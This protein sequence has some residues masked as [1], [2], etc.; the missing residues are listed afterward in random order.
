MKRNTGHIAERE[1]DVV[2]VG[3]GIFGCC[4][5][6]DAAQRGLS[7][8]LLERRDFSGATSANSFKIVHGGIRYLQ[9]GDLPRIRESSR[10]RSVLLKIAPHLVR[11]LPIVIPTYGHGKHG[12]ALLRLGC[13]VYDLLTLD[14]NR[15][16]TDA[17]RRIPPSRGLSREEVLEQ[18]PGLDPSGLTGGVLFHDGQMLDPP[19]LALCYLKSACEAGAQAA[20]YTEVTG[21]IR[22]GARVVGVEARDTLNGDE[23]DVRGKVVVNAAG[24]WVPKLLD[25][26]L[27]PERSPDLTFSR[28]ACFVVKRRLTG[29]CALAVSGRTRDP[30]A[31]LSRGKRHLF[32]APWRDYT[33]VGV[34]HKVHRSTPDDLLVTE[35][36]LDEFIAEVNETYPAAGISRDE[37]SVQN[38][39]LVLFGENRDGATDLSYGKRSLV[40]DHSTEHG[41]EGLISLVGVRYTTSRGVAERVV[42]LVHGKLEKPVTRSRTA[43]TPIFGG[44]TGDIEE[45]VAQQ[46]ARLT[47]KIDTASARA[48][49]LGHGTR[50][51][52]VI[53]LVDENP[54]LARSVGSSNVIRAQIVH[55]AREEMACKLSD[56]VCRRTDLCTGANPGDDAL[57]TSADIL[58]EELGWDKHRKRAELEEVREMVSPVQVQLA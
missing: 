4:C 40:L 16:I 39:G 41:I 53:R 28:D 11:P 7:V 50:H 2:V 57:T 10:E 27:G 43:S 44:D 42:D 13:R 34:W 48:L 21:L 30:D 31:L 54:E 8:A 32:L 58:A 37:V 29:S 6:W 55:A 23:F 49:L 12:K 20:N 47:S 15:G 19:R 52:E 1:F 56:V 46:T 33:L 5:A 9:H 36:E 26:M 14:R 17:A 22:D 35:N 24:P 18:F 45:F 25:K 38:S 3:G 51:G